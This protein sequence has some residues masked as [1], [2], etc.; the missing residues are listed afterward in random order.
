MELWLNKDLKYVRKAQ[1]YDQHLQ[2]QHINPQ[3]DFKSP[4]NYFFC[5]H[6]YRQTMLKI[7]PP[8]KKNK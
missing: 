3:G 2:V 1:S 8:P 5:F 7:C 4:I 6:A